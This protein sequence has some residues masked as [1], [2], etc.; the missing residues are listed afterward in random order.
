MTVMMMPLLML[1]S[2][3]MLPAAES[4]KRPRMRMWAVVGPVLVLM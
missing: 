2:S 4:S 3:I 1:L